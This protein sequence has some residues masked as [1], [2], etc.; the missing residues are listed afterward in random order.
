MSTVAYQSN[1]K[2]AAL[3]NNPVEICFTHTGGKNHLKRRSFRTSRS[4]CAPP[5]LTV[6]FFATQKKKQ[7]KMVTFT[8]KSNNSL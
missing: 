7:E 3:K 8:F 2:L 5:W 6:S 1:T 4:E